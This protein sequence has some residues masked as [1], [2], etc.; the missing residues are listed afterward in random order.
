MRVKLDT[1]LCQGH[2]ACAEEA[3]A[4][5]AVDEKKH[6]AVILVGEVP[7]SEIEAAKRAVKYCPTRALRLEE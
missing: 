7:A 4:L 3:P 6:L 2:G 5:F 1:D